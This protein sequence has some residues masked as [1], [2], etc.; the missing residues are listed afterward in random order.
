MEAWLAVERR[1]R[2]SAH[3]T[4][5]CD[6][7]GFIMSSLGGV[8]R[9]WLQFGRLD[10]RSRPEHAQ[11]RFPGHVADIWA[12]VERFGTCLIKLKPFHKLLILSSVSGARWCLFN[13]APVLFSCSKQRGL[14]VMRI[15]CFCLLNWYFFVFKILSFLSLCVHLCLTVVYM[16]QCF[17]PTASAMWAESDIQIE[18]LQQKKGTGRDG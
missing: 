18:K 8:R 6:R 12:S 13:G 14:S 17:S 15:R 3:L 7:I 16:L 2:C 10:G 1:N 5:S 9:W 4:A 11:I